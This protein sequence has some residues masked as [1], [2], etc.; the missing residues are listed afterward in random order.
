MHVQILSKR[1]GVKGYCQATKNMQGRELGRQAQTAKSTGTTTSTR[2]KKSSHY[3][4]SAAPNRGKQVGQTCPPQ[5]WHFSVGGTWVSSPHLVHLMSEGITSSFPSSADGSTWSRNIVL[6]RASRA[7]M[8][9]CRCEGWPSRLGTAS[10][11]DSDS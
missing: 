10:R 11:P 8:Q 3:G 4:H 9:A 6:G 5:L 7:E 2:R 1:E